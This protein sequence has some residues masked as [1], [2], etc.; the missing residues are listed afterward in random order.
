MT[1]DIGPRLR[2]LIERKRGPRQVSAVARD[3][4][5]A[6]AHLD[7]ILA[8]RRVPRLETLDKILAAIPATA[9]EL[10]GEESGP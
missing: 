10:F 6:V 9:A 3:A 5:L 4:G 2:R 1:P 8:G 7:Q